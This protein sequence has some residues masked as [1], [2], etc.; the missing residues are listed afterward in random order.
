[1]SALAAQAGAGPARA[2]QNQE[3]IQWGQNAAS[4]NLHQDLTLWLKERNSRM[5]VPAACPSGLL[6]AP[7]AAGPEAAN[8]KTIAPACSACALMTASLL[9]PLAAVLVILT[10]LAGALLP[11]LPGLPLMGMLTQ[12]VW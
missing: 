1:M 11:A 3:Q 6:F 7:F 5:P 2:H 12:L 9:L 8:L 10:G 4:R